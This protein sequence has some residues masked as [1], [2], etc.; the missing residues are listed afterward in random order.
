MDHIIRDRDA[1]HHLPQFNKVV[2]RLCSSISD[3]W[4]HLKESFGVDHESTQDSH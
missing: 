3:K 2:S 4:H 1:E